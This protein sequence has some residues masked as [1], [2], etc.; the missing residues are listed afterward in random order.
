[1]APTQAQLEAQRTQLASQID[2]LNKGALDYSTMDIKSFLTATGETQMAAKKEIPSYTDKYNEVFNKLKNVEFTVAGDAATSRTNDKAF[3]VYNS[4]VEAEKEATT[5]VKNIEQANSAY[6]A[7]QARFQSW[8]KTQE[9][10]AKTQA[11][12]LALQTYL[13]SFL[14]K[15]KDLT[16][17]IV[18]LDASQM[19]R[20]SAE[21]NTWKSAK[22]R[23]S[24]WVTK[25]DAYGKRYNELQYTYKLSEEET[26][27]R[28]DI[29]IAVETAR[30]KEDTTLQT[31][32]QKK[33]LGQLQNTLKGVD[34]S[35]AKLNKK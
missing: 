31:D 15:N 5:F 33:L 6:D 9:A 11:S 1:M 35:L 26:K 29:A 8:I 22:N 30:Y 18:R 21:W 12:E 34:S 7:Q 32:A 28:R 4:E 27:K 2:I 10:G 14:E 25:K 3:Y 17:G 24:V 23:S 13:N 20:G 19:T 16:K